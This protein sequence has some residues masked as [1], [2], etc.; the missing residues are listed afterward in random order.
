MIRATKIKVD[1]EV[2][3]VKSSYRIELKNLSAA[4]ARERVMD[5]LSAADVFTDTDRESKSSHVESPAG[6]IDDS[7][8]TLMDKLQTFIKFEY[9]DKWFSSQELKDKY[10]T[11]R[12]DIKLSTVSTYLSRMNR[13]GFLERKG[14]RNSRFYR[15]ASPIRS[16]AA[17]MMAE[18]SGA[19]AK[20]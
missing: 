16:E 7:G 18:R 2:D 4:E 13:D 5:Y 8:K 15:I 11:L 6:S 10:E 12:D 17:Q 19:S 14:N 3:G 20:L 9:P 1:L